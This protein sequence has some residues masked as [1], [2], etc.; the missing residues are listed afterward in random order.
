MRTSYAPPQTQNKKPL[1]NGNSKGALK[2]NV[3]L[4]I[5]QTNATQRTDFPALNANWE[6]QSRIKAT[7]EK[8]EAVSAAKERTDDFIKW[9][10]SVYY[11]GK[12]QQMAEENPE[13]YSFHFLEFLNA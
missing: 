5:M 3:N 4:F 13:A 10:D 12:A 11:E 8:I 2:N 6:I 7:I 1:M 9:M